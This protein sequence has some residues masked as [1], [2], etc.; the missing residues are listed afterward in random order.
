MKKLIGLGVLS[1]AL[2]AAPSA[3]AAGPH[4]VP[5]TPG[6]KNCYGQTAAFLAQSGKNFDEAYRGIGGIAKANGLTTQDVHAVIEQFCAS[7]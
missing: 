4:D 5:G 2:I 6:A 1:L 3:S 7:V